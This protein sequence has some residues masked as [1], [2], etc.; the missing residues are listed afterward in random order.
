[1]DVK[2]AL[3]GAGNVGQGFLTVLR[4]KREQLANR[5]GITFQ[6]VSVC[7][8]SQGSVTAAAGL[9]ISEILPILED[10]RC[11]LEYQTA[12]QACV[13]GLDPL[14]CLELSQ[15]D[16][17][18][19]CTHSNLQTGEPASGY[20][21]QALGLRRH[22]VSSNKGPAALNFQELRDL[23]KS[24]G[25]KYLFGAAVM[26]GTPLVNILRSSFRA[27]EVLEIRGLLNVTTNFVLAQ[28][29]KDK[30]AEVSVRE[31][32]EIGYSEAD[33]SLDLEG[34]DSLAKLMILLNALSDRQ[35]S[36]AQFVREG[37]TNI[38]VRDVQSARE[39][40]M[41]YRMV[42]HAWREEDASWRGQVG[43]V[44]MDERDPLYYVK[45]TRNAV[46]IKSETVGDI[47]LEGPGSG[48]LEVG[49]SMLLDLLSIYVP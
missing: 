46:Q 16:V 39:K 19:E 13:K 15:A 14:A 45:E 37:I 8:R 5:Y 20:I 27:D 3:I 23:A 41:R 4:K 48:R 49:Y 36:L 33:V 26:N 32:V 1:M 30:P 17:V 22:V 6:L 12:D 28:M 42:A 2:I 31:A 10:G 24:N 7:D 9:K 43:P 29:E 35:Q 44:K 21:R 40:S 18:L 11:L 34:Y 38:T 25:V 47:Y